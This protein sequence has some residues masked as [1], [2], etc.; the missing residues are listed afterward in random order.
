MNSEAKNQFE[1]VRK[2]SFLYNNHSTTAFPITAA[3]PDKEN[4]SER[5]IDAA[6]LSCSLEQLLLFMLSSLTTTR[7]YK[8]R[9]FLFFWIDNE[10]LNKV[11]SPDI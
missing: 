4:H 7:E 5:A 10:M 3:K 1:M 6:P 11:W 9:Y 8:C 2:D